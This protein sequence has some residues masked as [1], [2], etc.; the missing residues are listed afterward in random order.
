MKIS[1]LNTVH[2]SLEIAKAI[3]AILLAFSRQG[4][5]SYCPYRWHFHQNKRNAVNATVNRTYLWLV[6]S[7]SFFGRLHKEGFEGRSLAGSIIIDP[8]I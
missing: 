8:S 5:R 3:E 7:F 6:L 2:A 4:K 1:V